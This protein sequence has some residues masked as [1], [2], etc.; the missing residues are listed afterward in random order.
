M[1]VYHNMTQRYKFTECSLCSCVPHLLKEE[2]QHPCSLLFHTETSLLRLKSVSESL[3]VA[4]IEQ[5]SFVVL[6]MPVNKVQPSLKSVTQ[7]PPISR[8]K[9]KP[10]TRIGNGTSTNNSIRA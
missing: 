8:Q 4:L 7:L 1:R 9:H 5:C 3:K 10:R 6:T 2:F